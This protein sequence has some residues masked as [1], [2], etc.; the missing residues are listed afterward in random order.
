MSAI[1]IYQ[2]RSYIGKLRIGAEYAPPQNN[3]RKLMKTT[4]MRACF[5]FAFIGGM[6]AQNQPE[7]LKMPV[8]EVQN[9]IGR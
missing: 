6:F 1:G 3:R 9:L 7:T 8:P 2:Q 4:F 5:M